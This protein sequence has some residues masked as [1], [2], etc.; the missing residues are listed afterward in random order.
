MITS[1]K[2]L[3][4][5]YLKVNKKRSILTIIGIVLSVA[6]IST[7]GLF[8][9][10]IQEAEIESAKN[11]YGSFHLIFTKVD[12]NL[13]SKIMSNPKVSKSGFYTMGEHVKIGGKLTVNEII[14]TDKALELF[15]YKTK[16]GRLPQNED[17]AA[18]E[19][20]VLGY[21]DKDAKVGSEIKFNNKKYILTGILE[22]NV[23]SQIDNSGVLL[24]KKNNITK[25]N[26]ALLVEI[27]SKTNLK[28]AISELKAL[29]KKDTV[30]ENTYLLLM[31][32]VGSGGSG[33]AGL[34]G[35]IAIIIGIV[36]IST[37]A[38]IY[39]SFQISVVER[40][41]QFGLLR[42]V[43]A[44]P[45]QIRKIVVREASL[46][47]AIAIP[48]G[49]LCGV[50][51]INGIS[52][53]FKLIGGDSVL[54][55][56]ISI[57]TMVMVISG[58]VGLVSVYISALIPAF[59][60]GRISPLVAI[61][62]RASITKDKIKRRKSKI[63]GKIFGFEGVMADKNIRRNRKRYRVT[64]F[65]I[66]IS[67]VLFITF[68][69]FMDM[70][71]TIGNTLN[72][73]Q[74]IH[75]S[76]VRDTK[77]TNEGLTIDSKIIE[78]IKACKSVDKIYPIYDSYYFDIAM[79]RSNE[80]KEIQDMKKIYT[81]IN[82]NGSE[83]TLLKGS[84]SI[85]DRN[86][87][88]TAKKYLSSGKIDE[89]KLNKENGV[90]IIKKN[91]VYND[92]TKKTYYGPIADVKVGDEIDLQYN[93]L[94]KNTLE[95][96]KGKVS[97]VKVMA[98]V[99]EEPF[100]F[101]GNQEGLKIITTEEVGKKL[102]GKNE[103]KPINLNIVIKD[104]K[105]E[106]AAKTEIESAIK[107]N[108]SLSLINNIDQN[109]NGKSAMLIVKIL[110]YGFVVVVSLIGSV[111]II[112]T[113]TTNII[114]RKREFAA[115]KS[116]G[117]T[118]KGLKKTI[119]LEGLLYSIMGTIYGSVIGC[120]FS[121]LIFKGLGSVRELG[122]RIPWS[123]IGIAGSA[124]LFIGYLSVLAPLSRIKNENLI[125]AIREDY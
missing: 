50:I 85:Y 107:P 18:V 116:I 30:M 70:T 64:V 40:I 10:G 108:A 111:N 92:N 88:E 13:A 28:S 6:L 83:K 95:F 8:F 44:T 47:A 43:G 75:F 87:I 32:G 19:K 59:F 84:I 89:E 31:L 115:L 110:I 82:T 73:S 102:I 46:L 38:V 86:S 119:V 11:Q 27:N 55:M 14:A 1:Y 23:Q 16:E 117:L 66:V 120:G 41:K 52:F 21:I 29:G 68:K 112:N 63:I 114:L 65:S 42:A 113:L 90:I 121:Y 98:V 101:R 25:E 118:Q 105:N 7:I 125:E 104:I 72:E 33:L 5:K 69:A 60:A 39:N 79:S 48:L 124:A 93:E 76:V 123:A 94:Q 54:P 35:V 106:T 9:N 22:D 3:T 58:G 57:S 100:N 77:G 56:K 15:P 62:S 109:R 49:L 2:Q 122:F 24:S 97:K 91:R 20:W 26:A 74:N 4:G 61:S 34:Y 51:A 71:L 37:I 96:G 45:K 12:E 99:D 17:E 36:M 53:V 78:N 103:I 80:V 67:V 81:Q